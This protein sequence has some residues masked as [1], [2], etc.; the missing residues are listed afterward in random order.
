[1]NYSTLMSS[2][3][4]SN[5]Q[6]SLF[7]QIRDKLFECVYKHIVRNFG[8]K[9]NLNLKYCGLICFANIYHNSCQTV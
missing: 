9:T 5:T 6:L 4:H 1:M 3:I 2:F 7:C 8:S